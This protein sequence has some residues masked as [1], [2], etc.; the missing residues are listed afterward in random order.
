M[1]ASGRRC[2]GARHSARARTAETCGQSMAHHRGMA[3]LPAGVQPARCVR[4]RR[5]ASS[6]DVLVSAWGG[7]GLA[8]SE[9]MPLRWRGGRCDSRSSDADE[10]TAPA[11]RVTT[12]GRHANELADPAGATAAAGDASATAPP[13]AER[14]VN[15]RGV[16]A[17]GEGGRYDVVEPSHAARRPT[18]GTEGAFPTAVAATAARSTSRTASANNASPAT[19]AAA[20][21]AATT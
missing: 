19:T 3:A 16:N 13:D 5:E 21:T 7:G 14:S 4:T 11:A 2:D 9:P 20:A 8:P 10:R 6:P 18:R 12:D 17:A 1:A 15:R